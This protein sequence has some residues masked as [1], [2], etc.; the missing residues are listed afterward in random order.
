MKR[1]IYIVEDNP[2]VREA[3]IMLIQE[4][5]D[6]FVC[7]TAETA[8]EALAAIP[9]T[10][11]DLVLADFSLPGISGAELVGRLRA[12]N[13]QQRAVILSGHPESNY[14]EAALAAGATGYLHKGDPS[15]ILVGV[16]KALGDG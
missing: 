10:N 4:E 6:M 3:L 5:E 9:A 16:R 7:G 15:S 11:P 14:A 2:L 1:T 8:Q 12:L 13:P